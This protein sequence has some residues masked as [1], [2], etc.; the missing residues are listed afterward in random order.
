MTCYRRI[1]AGSGLAGLLLSVS[2]SNELSD[3]ELG[4]SVNA[5]KEIELS[6]SRL[7]FSNINV[8]E[9]N[10]VA[11]ELLA[12]GLIALDIR[13]ARDAMSQQAAVQG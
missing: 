8:E 13:Q 6:L 1:G 7:D 4:R 3:R 11:L 10:G 9:T 5:H 2:L 12:F